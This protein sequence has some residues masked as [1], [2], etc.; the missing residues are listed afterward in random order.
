[1]GKGALWKHYAANA[2]EGLSLEQS[3]SVE[4]SFHRQRKLGR[5]VASL[6][7]REPSKTNQVDKRRLQ[8]EFFCGREYRTCASNE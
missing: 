1:M 2:I 7:G 8:S 5:C 6:L 4:M 3:I